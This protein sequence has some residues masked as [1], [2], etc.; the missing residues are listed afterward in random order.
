M[1]GA[2]LAAPGAGAAS[3]FRVSGGPEGT[4]RAHRLV[5]EAIDRRDAVGA[6]ESMEALIASNARETERTVDDRPATG[7]TA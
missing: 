2:V 3:A 4:N 5:V 1:T 6:R 7:R